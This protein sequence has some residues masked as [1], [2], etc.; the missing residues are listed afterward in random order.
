MTPLDP[1]A[2]VALV[3][4]HQD[5]PSADL[6]EAVAARLGQVLVVGDGL[7]EGPTRTLRA[8]AGSHAFGV[9]LLPVRSGKGAA[10]AAGIARVLADAPSTEAVLVID[11]DGQHPAGAIPDFVAAAQHADLVIGDRFGDLRRIPPLRRIGNLIASAAVASSARRRVRDSQCGMRLLR[12]R[13]LHE[14]PFPSGGYEAETVHLKRCLA[15]GVTTAWV[16][17][18]AIYDGE[19]SSFRTVRDGVRVLRA[20]VKAP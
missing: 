14:I 10:V 16:P 5:A 9:L 12:G 1:S 4:C 3:P 18:P 20:A 19:P 2:V 13:A 15:A 8:L 7:A 11:G 17:I 6:L